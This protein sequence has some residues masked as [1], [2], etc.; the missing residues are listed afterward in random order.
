MP[1]NTL[2][3]SKD[4]IH[5]DQVINAADFVK[6]Q[7]RFKQRYSLLANNEILG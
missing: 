5:N 4:S 6:T 2:Q 3:A 7:G 1:D